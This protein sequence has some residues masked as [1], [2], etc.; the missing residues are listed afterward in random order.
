[1]SKVMHKA[2][3]RL[4]VLI[5]IVL[6]TYPF[7]VCWFE[8]YAERITNPFYM[9]GNWLI[10]ALFMILYAT[11]SHTYD[12]FI[13]S[14]NR[15]FEMVYSQCLALLMGK[16]KYQ[17]LFK[18][19]LIF[20]ISSFGTKLIT[21][22]L[23]PLY[24]NILSTADYGTADILSTTSSIS[25]YIFTICMA[26]AVL[27]F[28]IENIEKS[29]K[30]FSCAIKVLLKGSIIF[31]CMIAL[32]WKLRILSWETPMYVLLFLEY[33]FLAL[34]QI[35]SNYLR[36][37]GKVKE[38]A[39]AAI[40]TTACSVSANIILL[41]CLKK[42]VY[43]Y[44]VATVIGY[45]ASCIY[46]IRKTGVHFSELWIQQEKSIFLDM[47]KYSIPLVFNGI[48]WWISSGMNRYFIA[49]ICGVEE[50]GIYAVASKI[51]TILTTLS[52]IFS[53][54]WNLSAIKEFDKDDKDGFFAN[55]YTYYNAGLVLG[56]SGLV[57][58][59]IPLAKVLFAKDFFIAWEYSSILL[60]SSMFSALSLIPGSVFSAL[61]KS[62]MYA[63]STVVAGIVNLILN[64][65][66]I[67]V[68]GVYGAAVSTAIS[69][70]LV[71]LIRMICAGKY[72]KW[73]LNLLRDAVAY[74]LLIVQ[75]V[76][77]HTESH[78]YVLQIVILGVLVVLYRKTCIGFL[79][80]IKGQVKN[81]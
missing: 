75:T 24:T 20:T 5:N 72:I 37:I 44:L 16:S 12:A 14:Y 70:F 59:N 66:T 13:I 4:A 76:L 28:S 48:F 53:Q 38:V 40:I 36:A 41:V 47:S 62:K 80:M 77:E 7:T 61:G 11:F 45:I 8:Y 51:P 30:Y 42:G 79:G 64:V 23:L 10:I 35:L 60:L 73:K 29:K 78:A 67:P 57:L 32:A 25:V 52:S 74:V 31:A 69:F 2:V 34:N 21:F 27:R 49:G 50:N 63:V 68:W 43:G 18:N 54:A 1:M 65:I 81:A 55:I 6:M 26:D 15:I 39:I 71:W 19:T 58:F 9:K 46:C 3:L 33:F 17:F 56:C 22:F